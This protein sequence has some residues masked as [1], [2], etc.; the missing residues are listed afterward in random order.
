LDIL[1]QGVRNPI[2]NHELKQKADNIQT[3]PGIGKLTAV[4]ILAESPDFAYFSNARELAV[5]AG[6]TPKHKM[7]GT[8]V[9]GKRVI[10][11]KIVVV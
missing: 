6:L 4:A 9:R 11:Q 10:P 8:S 5:Y 2:H 7:S 3:I 1:I